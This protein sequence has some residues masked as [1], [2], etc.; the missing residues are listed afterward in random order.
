MHNCY[1]D[2]A[3]FGVFDDGSGSPQ[4][5]VLHYTHDGEGA[6]AV[7]ITDAGG[8]VVPGADASNTTPGPP[9]PPTPGDV[10]HAVSKQS[11]PY[12]VAGGTAQS[13]S[14]TFFAPG[15]VD[16]AAVPSGFTWSVSAPDGAFIST[17]VALDGAD[18]IVTEVS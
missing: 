8:A 17:P 3:V 14:V 9:E 10:S 12:T 15:E 13:V 11:G 7:R 2:T 1:N 4:P 16:S 18:Y 6:P 5:V